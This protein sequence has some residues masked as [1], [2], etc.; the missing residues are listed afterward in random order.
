MQG[1]VDLVERQLR[2]SRR[3]LVPVAASV[4]VLGIIVA[5][6]L[7][8][9]G[10]DDDPSVASILGS[11]PPAAVEPRAGPLVVPG[12]SSTAP[13]GCVDT[14][15]LPVDLGVP[16]D[17]CWGGP[18]EAFADGRTR[19][20]TDL[21]GSPLGVVVTAPDGRTTYLTQ[22]M[23]QSYAEIAGRSQ[24]VDSP[25]YGGYPVGI[26]RFTEPAAIAVRLDSG[27]LVLGPRDDTQMFWLPA[28]GVER[29]REAGGLRGELGFPASNLRLT[30][31][32]AFIEFQHGKLSVATADVGALQAGERV[33]IRMEIPATRPPGCP[34]T[35]SARRWCASGAASRGG[36]TPPAS[37]TGSPIR[38]R[39]AAS[40]ATAALYP[41]ADRF[42]D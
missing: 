5:G 24:P 6:A 31:N 29:W 10:G 3:R 37:A 32:G 35:R 41:G 33:P 34:S 27:G 8:L 28:E 42:V 9:V 39:G 23:W 14:D 21:A 17:A 12:P 25:A 2:P 20:V 19:R 1:W 36:S 4:V 11:A 38:R 22:T 30:F 16:S 13:A 15:P 26:E 40:V 7:L 18:E